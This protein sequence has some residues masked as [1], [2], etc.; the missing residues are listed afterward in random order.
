[1]IHPDKSLILVYGVSSQRQKEV[2]SHTHWQCGVT[3]IAS[4]SSVYRTKDACRKAY[5]I[6]VSLYKDQVLG[7]GNLN[8]LSMVKLYRTI[9]LTSH[10]L[11]RKGT[12]VRFIKN[13]STYA[14]EHAEILC[15]DDVT[16]WQE[17]KIL[18]NIIMHNVS[19]KFHR[20]VRRSTSPE[21]LADFQYRT[22]D[23]YLGRDLYRDYSKDSYRLEINRDSHKKY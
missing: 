3:P 16:V 10:A 12:L 5:G 14:W 8:P 20:I 9:T 19:S 6:M 17:C 11:F 13:Q 15:K 23:A 7:Q 2:A 18:H 1:M 21:I 4:K 22:Q